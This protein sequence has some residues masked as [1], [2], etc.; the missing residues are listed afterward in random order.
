LILVQSLDTTAALFTNEIQQPLRD[1]IKSFLE[2]PV[3][4]IECWRHN[5]PKLSEC[6][7]QNAGSHLRATVLG[8]TLSLPVRDGVLALGHWQSIILAELDG[9]RNRSV[10]VHVLSVSEESN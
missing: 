4:R 5:D 10:Q 6:N 9:P 3:G 2:R 7:Q 8:R 1:N